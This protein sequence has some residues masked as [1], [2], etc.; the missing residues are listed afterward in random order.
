[1]LWVRRNHSWLP[2][3]I[4]IPNDGRCKNWRHFHTDTTDD[5][6][7]TYK[8]TLTINS[9]LC[10]LSHK[11]ASTSADCQANIIAMRHFACHLW[12]ISAKLAL[13][14][15]AGSP[16]RATTDIKVWCNFQPLGGAFISR[17][18][19]FRVQQPMTR[20]ALF[21]QFSIAYIRHKQTSVHEWKPAISAWRRP[22]RWAVA[23]WRPS[24]GWTTNTEWTP[25][26]ASRTDNRCRYLITVNC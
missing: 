9:L 25:L 8:P 24:A 20:A 4:R 7:S 10:H 13:Q 17:I 19:A 1:M 12:A 22:R 11:T 26:P 21:V 3:K 16:I 18:R 5:V 15:P 23:D 14:R 6:Y 2:Q